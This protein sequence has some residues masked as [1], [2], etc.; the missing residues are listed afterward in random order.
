MIDE[1]SPYSTEMGQL[2]EWISH[3]YTNGYWH[4]GG[5]TTGFSDLP[6]TSS[7]YSYIARRCEA[8]YDVELNCWN[9]NKR[10]FRQ[11]NMNTGWIQSQWTEMINA[12]NLAQFTGLATASIEE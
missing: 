8:G 1:D 12:G 3:L 2:F 9:S 5:N 11:C 10:Y 6:N 7:R 4:F